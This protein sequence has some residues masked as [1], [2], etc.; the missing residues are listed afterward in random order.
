ME[1]RV[2]RRVERHVEKPV[3]NLRAEATANGGDRSMVFFFVGIVP[4][5]GHPI[6]GLLQ[7]ELDFG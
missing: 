4:S 1:K 3:E 5:L 2:E 6:D 7:T